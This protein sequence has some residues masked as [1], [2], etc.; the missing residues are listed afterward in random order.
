MPVS[1]WKQHTFSLATDP[2]S[3]LTNARLTTVMGGIAVDLISAP[4]EPGTYDIRFAAAMGGITMFLPACAEV[5]TGGRSFW[6]GTR[7]R[8]A[9]QFW[10]EM[11]R[12]FATSS[13]RVPSTPPA[14]AIQPHDQRAVTLRIS[15]NSLMGGIE[16]YQLEPEVVAS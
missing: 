10:T 15:A 5:Q 7:L 6:G 2:L 9:E 1:M 14:W 16:I 13:V 3:D 8:G 4:I 12:V 11:R